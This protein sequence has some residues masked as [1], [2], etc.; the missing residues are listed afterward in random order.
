MATA[1]LLHRGSF[2]RL[3]VMTHLKNS[4]MLKQGKSF[5]NLR[6]F[7]NI[8][9]SEL[10]FYAKNILSISRLSY[11]HHT[12]AARRDLCPDSFREKLSRFISLLSQKQIIINPISEDPSQV[13]LKQ[14]LWKGQ[15]LLKTL[16]ESCQ[17]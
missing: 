4:C 11:L 8:N 12:Q 1:P 6:I 13:S 2:S 5:L 9:F 3:S 14:I 10:V 16:L 17:K 15:K 7:L